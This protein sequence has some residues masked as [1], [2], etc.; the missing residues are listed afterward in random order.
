MDRR[1]ART[2]R[3]IRKAVLELI[4]RKPIAEISITELAEKADIDR[5]TFYAHY[6]TV[7]DV[8]LEMEEEIAGQVRE[9]LSDKEKLEIHDILD[10]L[11][12]I[13]DENR[14]FYRQ[15]SSNSSVS[16][17]KEQCILSL[18]NSYAIITLFLPYIF[19]K[20]L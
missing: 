5:R 12:R 9:I 17:L 13:M 3:N 8:I 16:F 18:T 15:I 10:G 2:K 19:L 1:L 6:G 4:E 20:V 7:M 14:E 11:N